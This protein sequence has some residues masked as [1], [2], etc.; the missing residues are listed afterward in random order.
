MIGYDTL[1]P[2]AD[3]RTA[4]LQ[5]IRDRVLSTV[6]AWRGLPEYGTNLLPSVRSGVV[7]E[8]ASLLVSAIRQQLARDGALYA[9]DD[10]S[11]ITVGA[12][13]T[14][15]IRANDIEFRMDLSAE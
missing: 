5:A 7:E 15:T 12:V 6:G 8:E 10:V 1:A 13:T 9:V 4:S 14:L 2:V 11:I 3:A